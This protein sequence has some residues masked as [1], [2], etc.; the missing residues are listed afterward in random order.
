VNGLRKPQATPPKPPR[1]RAVTEVHLAVVDPTSGKAGAPTPTERQAI[2]LAMLRKGDPA[3][4]WITH[5]AAAWGLT[6][7][8]IS[9]ELKEARAVLEASRTPDAALIQAHELI[10]QAVEAADQ[11]DHEADAVDDPADR[12]DIRGKAAGLKLKAAAELRQL[13]RKGG[14]LVDAMV[15]AQALAAQRQAGGLA[16]LKGGAGGG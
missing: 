2:Y 1:R 4:R 8:A 16:G 5:Q 3:P 12:A 7:A 9:Q 14:G 13:Y 6:H 10:Q 11:I 15:E